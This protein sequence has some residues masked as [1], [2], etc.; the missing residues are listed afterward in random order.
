MKKAFAIVIIVLA[1]W[2][3]S[4][5]LELWKKDNFVA[6]YYPNVNDLSKEIKIGQLGSI[7]E[8]RSW[9]DN[10]KSLRGYKGGDDYECGKNC[11]YKSEYEMYVCETTER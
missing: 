6:I 7:E 11:K 10:Q 5:N 9:I 2:F 1:M 4:D 3:V 8:C